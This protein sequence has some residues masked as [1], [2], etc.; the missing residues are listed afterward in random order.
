MTCTI[1]I[2]LIYERRLAGKLLHAH[3]KQDD[4]EVNFFQN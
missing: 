1:L 2:A 4:Q 3:M